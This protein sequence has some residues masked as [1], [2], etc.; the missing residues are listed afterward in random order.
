MEL[1]LFKYKKKSLMPP[2]S[3]RSGMVLYLLCLLCLLTVPET[4]ETYKLL[5][6][7]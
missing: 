6:E 1:A 4:V 7:L 2:P 5:D 3:P